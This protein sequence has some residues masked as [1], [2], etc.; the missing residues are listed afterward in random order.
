VRWLLIAQFAAHGP[1]IVLAQLLHAA[2]FGLY[3]A[4]AIYLVHKLFTGAHQGRGQALYS[5]VSF[6]AGG[7][8]GSL[9]S[10]YLWH[11]INPPAMFLLAA[12]ASLAAL[13]VI[14]RGM[15]GEY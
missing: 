15:R 5:S 3:H 4:V 6:G 8:T 14:L 12:V 10:G 2:S 9:V 11:G 7:A 1:L 13:L